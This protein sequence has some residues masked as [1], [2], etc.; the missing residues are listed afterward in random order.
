MPDVPARRSDARQNR[1]ALLR[2]SGELLAES[3]PG[4]SLNA[5]A[6][7]AGVGTAT[8][9]R[10][11]AGA[12]EVVEAYLDG[13]TGDLLTALDAVPPGDPLV[14]LRR[15][16]AIWVAKAADWGVAVAA[17]RSARGFLARLDEGDAFIVA[18]HQRLAAVLTECVRAGHLPRQEMR[19]AVLTW[20]TLFDERVVTD[21][22]ASNGWS[23]DRVARRL[24]TTLLR[25]YGRAE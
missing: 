20:I 9:Y 22:V 2:A 17:V 13:L 16:C 19:Y 18:L 12:R 25:A 24:T 8:A 14:R 23:P 15:M 10:H 6:H 21:L 5:I 11:F 7:R 4:F 1:A 3:G